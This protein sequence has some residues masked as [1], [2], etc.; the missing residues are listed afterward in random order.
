VCDGGDRFWSVLFDPRTLRFF[1]PRFN[2]HL[3]SGP[4]RTQRP[5]ADGGHDPRGSGGTHGQ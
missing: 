2:G 5:G 1:S 3:T 4:Q